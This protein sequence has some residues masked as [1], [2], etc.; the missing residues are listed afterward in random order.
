MLYNIAKAFLLLKQILIKI[1]NK[2][3]TTSPLCNKNRSLYI[4]MYL[5]LHN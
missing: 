2:S 4:D 3:P 1:P 5:L